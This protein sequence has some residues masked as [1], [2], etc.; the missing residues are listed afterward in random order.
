MTHIH[1]GQYCYS[2]KHL[3]FTSGEIK[4]EFLCNQTVQQHY[5]MQQATLEGWACCNVQQTPKSAL[6]WQHSEASPGSENQGAGCFFCQNLSTIWSPHLAKRKKWFITLLQ[7]TFWE[8][9]QAHQSMHLLFPK[10]AKQSQ[11]SGL[12]DWPGLHRRQH[13]IRREGEEGR[14][15]TLGVWDTKT[16]ATNFASSFWRDFNMEKTSENQKHNPMCY[17]D[18]STRH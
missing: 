5:V 1:T 15:S 12:K 18:A 14:K 17:R 8:R 3:A 2:S 7:G 13:C 9:K 10:K 4:S 16:S 6:A 11:W